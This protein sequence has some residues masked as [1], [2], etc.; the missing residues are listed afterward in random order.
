MLTSQQAE[1][2][3]ERWES[4]QDRCVPDREERFT[5]IADVVQEASGRDDPLIVD[6]G[7]G[8]A[9]LAV[10]LLDRLPGAEVVGVDADPLLLGLARMGH[11]DQHRL[12][13]IEH[14][15]REPGWVEAMALNRPVDAFVSTTA[16]HWLTGPELAEVYRECAALARPGAA[17][18]NG[19]HLHLGAGSARIDSLTRTVTERRAERAPES[20]GEDWESWWQAATGATELAEL[21]TARGP[22]GV[23]HIDNPATLEQHV[24]HLLQAGFSEAGTV[25]QHGDNHVL[26]GVW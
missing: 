23:H 24:R 16:L 12:R 25:W 1:Q 14:D 11:A 7:T 5:V 22:D 20:A 8:P 18:V 17:M 4:Q 15:I 2:W 9:S 26:V 13:L 21:V 10:R 3:L 6:L 19:D